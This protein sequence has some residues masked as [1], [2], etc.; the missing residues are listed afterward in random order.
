MKTI[1][2]V[3]HAE[4]SFKPFEKDIDRTLTSSGKR[5]AGEMARKLL[6]KE[7]I[8]ENFIS[9]PAERAIETA[10]IFMDALGTN[11]KDIQI[12]NDLY[13]P[14][15]QSFYKVIEN[16]P[17]S[18]DSVIIFSHNPAITLFVNEL[19]CQP[20]FDMPACGMYA[21]QIHAKKWNELQIADKSFLF[22]EFPKV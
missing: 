10:S 17:D 9:S 6:E 1:F 20:V 19:D 8:P 15:V 3:R 5:N 13:E 4:S 2:F 16:I 12:E 14:T 21:V 7:L 11:D 22:Y 18:I